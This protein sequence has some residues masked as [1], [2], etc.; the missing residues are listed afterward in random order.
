MKKVLWLVF[1][2]LIA[3]GLT[4]SCKPK[5]KPVV[6]TTPQVKEQ[7]KVEKV[8][9]PAPVKKPEMTEEELFMNK[10]LEALNKEK[11]LQMIYFDYDKY[12]IR[13]DAKSVLEANAAWMK[14][15]PTTKILVEG[16]CDERGTEEYNLALGDKRSKS[17]HEYLLSLG[18]P[19]ERMKTI[20]YGKSQPLDMGHNEAAWAKNRRG[21]FL[22]IEK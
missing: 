15:W 6:P 21:Q 4:V 19:A 7:P 8:V 16:H 18:V 14:K 13:D 2:G 9:E 10:S 17:A 1:I 12:F 11:P 20:S 3:V 22:I 5:T